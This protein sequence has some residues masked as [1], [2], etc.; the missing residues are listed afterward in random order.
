MKQWKFLQALSLLVAFALAVV[1]G[2]ASCSNGSDGNSAVFGGT[3]TGETNP[4]TPTTPTNPTTPTTPT[5]PTN[6]TIPTTPA[7]YTITFNANDGS[8]VPATATQDFVDGTPQALT[9]VEDLGFSKAGFNFAGW[10]TSAD[11]TESAY[12]DGAS[13][14]A[15][16]AATLYAMWSAIPV[17]SVNIP[18][19][20]YGSVTA[21][22]A[23]ATAGTEITLSNTPNAGYQFISYSVIDA[24][25]TTVTVTDGKFTMP[26]K[27]V[28]VT[29][30]F[31]AINY[32][33]N[34]V[35]TA[36]GSVMTDKA[37]AAV[38]T[39]V[40]ITTRPANNYELATLIV[41]D[42]DGTS[43]TVSGTGNSRTFV[44]PAKNVDVAATFKGISYSIDLRPMEHGSVTADPAIATVGTSVTLT[45]VAELDYKLA[46]LNA[47]V[48][49]GPSLYSAITVTGTGNV[50]TFTMPAQNVVVIATFTPLPPAV[51]GVYK[52]N[53]KTKIDGTLYN[54]VTFGLWPQTIKADDVDIDESQTKT[55]GSFTYCRGS[56]G[57]WYAKLK[58]TIHVDGCKYSDG[59]AIAYYGGGVARWIWFR[60][61]PIKWRVLTNNYN[62][63]G[64]KL[65]L[66]ENVLIGR[67]YDEKNGSY[68]YQ[69]SEIRKWLN[70]NANSASM[71][72]HNSLGGF[73][74]AAFT[75]NDELAK[76][77]DTNVD[78]SD[79][80]TTDK[81]F[82][83]NR[84]ETL[85]SE[86]GF[87]DANTRIRNMT[88]YATASGADLY[89][90]FGEGGDWWLRFSSSDNWDDGYVG[91][92]GSRGDKVY[93]PIS[94]VNGVVP[95]L[96]VEN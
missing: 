26:A 23:T 59:T 54:L 43:V 56:D 86:Y 72:D 7:T 34:V 75:T 47:Y 67:R 5:D 39:C 32:N 6:P 57:Q 44:M 81:V 14:T 65:L 4:T 46:T 68:N 96:C 69:N 19:N 91:V 71:S 24:D 55:A 35:T 33:I 74:K 29:V 93:S 31:T 9:L 25:G 95:A 17:Y 79:S 83:L 28:T 64:K 76:I 2:F 45:A 87:G 73:L 70:S 90:G 51:S 66:A 88:D 60:V 94:S 40:T 77:V 49:S 10:G 11:A 21:S 89:G 63:T 36:N 61:E 85:K 42:S 13:Y 20:E 53:G 52:E 37:T 30:T 84:Q 50:R 3:N 82:L 8:E 16:A 80:L 62:G 22:P 38:G 18:V 41:T 58:E 92:T 12:A 15:S 27:D 48:E 78:S 1:F